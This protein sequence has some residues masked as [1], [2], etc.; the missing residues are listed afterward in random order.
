M[1]KYLLT[2]AMSMAF[3]C[4]CAQ[5]DVQ[6][7]YDLGHNIYSDAENSRQALTATFEF[8]RPD[9]LGSTFMFID[10]D[11]HSESD[12]FNGVFGTYCDISRDFNIRP[13]NANNILTA[14]FQYTGGHNTMAGSYQQA[15]MVGPAWQW[16]SN[17][18]SRMF[19]L[20]LSYKQYFKHLANEAHPSFQVATIWNLNFCQGLLSFNGLAE[21]WYGYIPKFSNM[22]KQQK[23]IAL[24]AEPQFWVNL[25]GRDRL[26]DKLSIGTEWELSNNFIW[27]S[28]GDRTFYINPTIAVK[29]TF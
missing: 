12:A 29:Y 21:M 6:L 2:S 19:I 27:A 3:T 20:Q 25:T 11:F 23:G 5:Y 26:N 18:F 17:D 7:H 28:W 13:L 14:H 1:K 8:L 10:L 15:M 24:L 9:K 4:V 16:H 22:G